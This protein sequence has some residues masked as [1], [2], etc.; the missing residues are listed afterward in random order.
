MHLTQHPW[1]FLWKTHG[2][3]PDALILELI[4]KATTLRLKQCPRLNWVVNTLAHRSIYTHVSIKETMKT[5]W[6]KQVGQPL[7]KLK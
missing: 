6:R 1:C 3:H 4:L 7:S 2:W 5:F